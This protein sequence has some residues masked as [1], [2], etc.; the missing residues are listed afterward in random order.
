V[1]TITENLASVS[2]TTLEAIVG[3]QQRIVDIHR[4]FASVLSGLLPDVPSWLQPSDDVD[5]TDPKQL[6]EQGFSFQSRLLEA[7]K[8]FSMGLIEAWAQ[9]ASSVSD[10][11]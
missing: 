2:D 5:T 4:E 10:K 1:S 11:S 7:N 3:I 6:V 8:E 9:P